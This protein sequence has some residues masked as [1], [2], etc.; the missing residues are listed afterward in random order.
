MNFKA[1]H[2]PG[3]IGYLLILAIFVTLAA[4]ALI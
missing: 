4:P 1:K 3:I 2:E